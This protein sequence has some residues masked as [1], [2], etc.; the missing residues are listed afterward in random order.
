MKF[1]LKDVVSNPFRRTEKY[2]IS[3][4]KVA[5]LIESIESTGFWENIVGR[6]VD[7]KLQIA[8]GHH[9][10]A[11][12]KEVYPGTQ[13]FDWRVRTLTD[14]EMIQIMARENSETYRMNAAVLLES[15]RATVAAYAKG[16]ITINEMPPPEAK[17][18]D[19]NTRYAPSFVMGGCVPVSGTH[20]YTAIT[21]GRFLGLTKKGGQG[22]QAA[23]RLL[24]AL[25]ALE[26]IEMGILRESEVKDLSVTELDR[27]VGMHKARVEE[28]KAL[29]SKA[30]RAK[31][32]AAK[33]AER[34]AEEK[35]KA[36]KAREAAE[37]AN[38]LAELEA[39]QKAAQE[40]ARKAAEKAAKEAA[41]AKAEA[42]RKQDAAAQKAAEVARKAAEEARERAQQLEEKR[43][44]A[45]ADHKKAEEEAEKAEEEARKAKEVGDKK[46]KAAEDAEKRKEAGYS[47]RQAQ[48]RE[49]EEAAA[50]VAKLKVY[51][52]KA[53]FKDL[54]VRMAPANGG[55][56][57]GVARLNE[58]Y[59]QLLAAHKE[60]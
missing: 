6:E 42:K 45:E 52:I 39:E 9:R 29:A 23:A 35:R 12:L 34:Q 1:Q 13:A 59:K 36:I 49:E 41:D 31:E 48:Q 53:G 2:P 54:S 40:K 30:A 21:L 55:N 19:T 25:N 60:D 47:E 20:P 33:E 11:A 26:M 5:A 16:Q 56:A 24:T 44:K 17:V 27:M 7:G 8:Y 3:P 46:R 28:K 57:K 22:E 10:L 51:I 38:R 58:A 14:G 15:V 43:K 50:H 37:E 32:E 4:E 18:R